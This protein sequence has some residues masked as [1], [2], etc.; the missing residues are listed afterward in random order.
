[1]EETHERSLTMRIFVAGATGVL[2][3]RL[4]PLLVEGGHQVT[5]MTRT[6]GKAAGLRA[7]GAEPVVADA[8]D[9]DAVLR[10]VVAARPEVV[11]HQLTALAGTISFRRFD[12]AFALTNRLRT[13]GTDHL[14]EAARA[15]GTRRFVAQSF[16][17]WPFARVGGPVKTEG[18]PLDPDP[19]AELRRTLDA[20]R[21]L[22]SAVL[23]TEGIEGVV[24]RYGGFYGPGTS[25]GAGG[26][27]LEDLRRRRFP[28]VGAG[29]GVWSFIHIDDAAAATVAAVERGAPGIYQIVDDD[30]APVSAWLPAL[31]AAVGAPPP[32][33]VPAWMGRLVAGEHAVVLMTGARGASNAK[34]RRELGWRPGWRS[35]RQ[36]FRDGL[37]EPAAGPDQARKVS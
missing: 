35:W 25:A 10:A 16:A 8:L 31:A 37:G 1:M 15:A 6:P 32:R 14:L 33:R 22:E 18:D 2:G 30:P 11:V 12:Q 29:T 21:H 26:S 7:T 13:E 34:A 9:R 36:G 4:V 23:G 24:L 17:G 19:P 27:M 5:A 28:V 20:I 3:R